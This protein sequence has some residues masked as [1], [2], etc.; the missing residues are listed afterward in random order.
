MSSP[1]GMKREYPWGTRM[2][3]SGRGPSDPRRMQAVTRRYPFDP[4][5][6][7]ASTVF[8]S[9]RIVLCPITSPATVPK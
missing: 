7:S 8:R 9:R 6:L 4:G 2:R 5:A 3:G 1:A